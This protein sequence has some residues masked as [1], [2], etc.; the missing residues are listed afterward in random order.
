MLHFSHDLMSQRTLVFWVMTSFGVRVKV[1]VRVRIRPFRGML[2]PSHPWPAPSFPQRAQGPKGKVGFR[3]WVGIGKGG[4][5]M[6]VGFVRG[7]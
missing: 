5:A 4:H 7:K 3:V 6:P 2:G 1:R